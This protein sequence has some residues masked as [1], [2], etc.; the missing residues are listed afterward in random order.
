M[1]VETCLSPSFAFNLFISFNHGTL[2]IINSQVFPFDV[3]YRR[4]LLTHEV[5]HGEFG[6]INSCDYVIPT[7]VMTK[8]AVGLL[9]AN[10]FFQ[11]TRWYR[12]P[13]LRIHIPG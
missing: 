13:G 9:L 7:T 4:F 11:K 1:R 6:V 12:L 2:K 8:I 10:F 3:M 5:I